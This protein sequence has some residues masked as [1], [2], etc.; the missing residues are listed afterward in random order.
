MEIPRRTPLSVLIAALLANG[1]VQA[2]TANTASEEESE[3]LET[4]VVTGTRRA[5]VAPT[6]TM[7]PIDVVTGDSLQQH[8]SFDLTDSLT[9][10]APAFNT[11]RFPIA[12]GTAV[13]R[14][15]SLRNL[16]PDQTL[17]LVNG[18]R[19]H[20]SALVNLQIAP[21][22]TV[23]QGAQ[24]VDFQTIPTAA[25]SRVEVLR[26][27]AASQYGSDAIAG[28]VN[29]ILNDASEG[30]T[31]SAQ[32]GEYYEGDGSRHSFSINGGFELGHR[33]FL[34]TTF[35]YSESDITSRGVAR[36][37]AQFVESVV[38]PGVVPL[39]GLGQR[40]GDP[41]VE[42]AKLF[43]N[44]GFEISDR[45]RFDAHASY[46]RIDMVSDFFYREPVLDPEF[47]F[48]GRATLQV[49]TV[50]DFRPDPA[51]QSLIDE[52]VASGLNPADYLVADADSPSG[53]VLRNPIFSQ[54]PGG[55]NPN[56]GAGIEDFAVVGG[57]SGQLANDWDWNLRARHAENR[58]VYE[59][60][61]TI[62]PSLGRLS[63]TEFRPGSL[64][65]EESSLNL[66]FVRLYFLGDG[67]TPLNVAFG[68]EYRTE[69]YRIGPGDEAST[70]VG[71][72]AAFF[73][74]GSDG[75]QG[76][77]ADAV[78]SFDSDSF[79]TY[80]DL[81]TDLTD[82]FTAGLALR[83]EDYDRFGSTFDYKLSGRYAFTP[84]FAIRSTFSTG[85]RAP[86][87]GQV[88]TQNVTT[89][90]NADGELIPNGTY[91]VDH[92]VSIVLGAQPLVPEESESFTIG[93]VW[94]W[95]NRT[96]VTLDFYHIE[97]NDRIALQ[98]NQVTQ[99]EVDALQAIGFPDANLLLGTNANFFSNAFDSRIS[100]V[101]LSLA[102]SFELGQGL[103][104]MDL[105]HNYNRQ[106]VRN[107][108]PNTINASR[109][110]DLENQ[111]PSQRSV[112]TFD[113]TSYGAWAGMVRLNRY[114]SWSTTGG[115]FSPGDASDV[116]RYSS[117]ILVD[118]ELRFQ[119]MD[120]YEL[121]VGGQNIF[122]TYP[123]REANPTLNFLGVEHA[124]TSPFGFNGGFWYLRGVARF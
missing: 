61:E 85:F 59:V 68:G 9:N 114:G 7:S 56:F 26:D 60:S 53:F 6:D 70:A 52:I 110:Y 47:G 50:G 11:Q 91:P 109:V 120:R 100:G 37:D 23:N 99:A 73:G 116:N 19:R 62:N 76:F 1:L 18:T 104:N 108:A 44:S 34:N 25:I 45:V 81:E 38:G 63:P 51:P 88:S 20:R 4:I 22:G 14:P 17:V 13:I 36:S 72:T 57:F 29:V 41:D 95:D 64:R 77:S 24:A 122:D 101:D 27:G 49:D 89:T 67:A 58:L 55:Y 107:V 31:L 65:Q 54:F 39:D 106:K 84:D 111:V 8:G 87:A 74:L 48:S 75:F 86:T 83:F 28:V 115:L 112:L 71:P 97:V 5:G 30:W 43:L 119:F 90:A 78:G 98:N 3:A 69:T 10:I 123:D 118:A 105:R 35:E 33:G 16:S 32:T 94:D 66:D 82:R 79:A 113:Y 15:V 92:P 21:L 102:R 46:A 117:E 80:L 40:W 2:E 103:M 121:A 42:A 93:A 12:D 124:L 96:S